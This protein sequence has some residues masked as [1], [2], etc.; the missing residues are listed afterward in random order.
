MIKTTLAVVASLLLAACGGGEDPKGTNPDDKNA[1]N[2]AAPQG[3]DS[4]GANA[5]ANNN[6]AGNKP[7]S[8]V[9]ELTL[10]YFN[11]EG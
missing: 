6:A 3:N 10:T 1:A 4:D 11:L 7:L 9:P 8:A 2:Q 5:G